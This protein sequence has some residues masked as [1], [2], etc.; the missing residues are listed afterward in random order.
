M[1]WELAAVEGWR[2][3][4]RV[5]TIG[6]STP[7]CTDPILEIRALRIGSHPYFLFLMELACLKAIES[8]AF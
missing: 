4:R 8:L 5:R 6:P 3:G 2:E 1:S 7:T